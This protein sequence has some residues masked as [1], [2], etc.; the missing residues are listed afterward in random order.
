VPN[1]ETQL[2]RAWERS[3]LTLQQLRD[4]AKLKMSIVSV[5]RKLRGLQTISAEEASAFAKVLG[6]RVEIGK[7]R[8][9]GL[10]A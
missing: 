5:S 2:H 4:K 1:S 6:E 3:G 10:A 9:R 8:R 7:E